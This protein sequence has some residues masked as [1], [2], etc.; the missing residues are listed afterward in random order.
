MPIQTKRTTISKNKEKKKGFRFCSD[1]LANTERYLLRRTDLNHAYSIQ[2]E[3]SM[4][5]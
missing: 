2:S 4:E 1:L 3:K 5:I